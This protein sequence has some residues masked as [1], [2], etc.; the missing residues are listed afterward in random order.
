MG[1]RSP[2]HEPDFRFVFIVSEDLDFSLRDYNSG[3][4]NLYSATAII[5]FS[6]YRRAHV[7]IYVHTYIYTHT[8]IIITY[9]TLATLHLKYTTL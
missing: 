3:P 4:L 9:N 8:L 7:Y 2:N 5:R 1:A 6:S